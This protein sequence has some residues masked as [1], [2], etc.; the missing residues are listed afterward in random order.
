MLDKH[1]NMVP[2]PVA[3]QEALYGKGATHEGHGWATS[4]ALGYSSDLDGFPYDPA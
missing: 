1:Y 3:I 2:T 4:N